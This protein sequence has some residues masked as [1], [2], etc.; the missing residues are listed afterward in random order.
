MKG[1]VLSLFPGADLWGQAFE[2]EGFS[3]VKGPDVLMGGDIRSFH[4]VPGRFDVVIG[5]PPCKS[6]SQAIQSRGGGSA[7]LEGNLIP[8]F[9]RVVSEATPKVWVMENVPQAPIPDLAVYN[10]ICDAWEYG[11]KQHRV[12][13]FSSNQILNIGSYK[14]SEDLRD[15]D[16]FPCVTATEYKCSAGSGERSMRQR[17]GRKVGRK[18]T[19]EEMKDLMGLPQ[20]F[21]TPCLTQKYQYAILGNG[22]PIQ[23]GRS[24]ARAVAKRLVDTT[25]LKG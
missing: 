18:L 21:V 8:E 20:T 17:A 22:V 19:L 11:A 13:R 3:V 4:T 5:G 9:E 2:Q 16:P 10:E 7:A 14:V 6:F 25:S 23:M 24:V 15:P 1:L 12:R